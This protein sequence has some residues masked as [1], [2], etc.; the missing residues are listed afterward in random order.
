MKPS[1]TCKRIIPC[2]A[3]I[4]NGHVWDIKYSRTFLIFTSLIFTVG[5]DNLLGRIVV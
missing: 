3:Q 2:F 1:A 4:I 5:N